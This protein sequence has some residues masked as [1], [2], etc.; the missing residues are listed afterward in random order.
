VVVVVGVLR[1]DLGAFARV[2]ALSAAPP[3]IEEGSRLVNKHFYDRET[4]ERVWAQA[5]AAWRPRDA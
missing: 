2:D 4:V 3:L 5:R 1:F